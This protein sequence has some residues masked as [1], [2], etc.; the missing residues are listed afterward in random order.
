MHSMHFVKRLAPL[1]LACLFF[2]TAASNALADPKD[3]FYQELKGEDSSGAV[4]V[5]YCLEL[6]R[7]DGAPTLCNNRFPFSSGDGIRLHVKTTA[8]A[9]AYIGLVG[10]SGKK[11]VIYPPSTTSI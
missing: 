6:H 4:S 3:M 5:A 7:G 10:S 1:L 11:S 8:P 2:L 9:Y